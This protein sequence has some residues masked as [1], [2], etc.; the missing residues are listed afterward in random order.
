MVREMYAAG[1]SIEGHG[2]NHVSLANKDHDYLVWQAL[3][4]Y[5]AIQRELGVRPHFLA[6]PAGEYDQATI[7]MFRSANFWAA[8]TT[9]QGA[10]HRSDDLF[11]LKRVRV[12]GTTTPEQLLNLLALDW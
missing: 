11:E 2:R 6:Y 4:S 1:M 3:G 10:T 12:H 8:V 9:R 7:D 5:E